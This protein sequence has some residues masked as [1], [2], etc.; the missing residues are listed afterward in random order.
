MSGT[1]VHMASLCKYVHALLSRH[2]TTQGQMRTDQPSCCRPRSA[3][4]GMLR[5]ELQSGR[6]SFLWVINFD[7]MPSL[8]CLSRALSSISSTIL[9]SGEGWP[10]APRPGSFST[11]VPPD[12][13]RPGNLCIT[14]SELASRSCQSTRICESLLSLASR[15][16]A[17]G[18]QLLFQTVRVLSLPVVCMSDALQ[19]DSA[20]MT[21]VLQV[22]YHGN[23]GATC[24]EP[25]NIS[26]AEIGHLQRSLSAGSSFLRFCGRNIGESTHC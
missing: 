2:Q 15:V 23:S 11:R 16:G 1:F 13:R 14:S 8:T 21:D 17:P 12:S 26:L 22:W 10:R 20:T 3:F 5:N 7:T 4:V 19:Y 25:R 18:A 6:P 24:F 9:H